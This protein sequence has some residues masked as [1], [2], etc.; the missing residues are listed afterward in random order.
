MKHVKHDDPAVAF[1]KSDLGRF[2]A[3]LP[4]RI[5]QLYSS[6]ALLSLVRW[7][8]PVLAMICK[9]PASSVT[10]ISRYHGRDYR[11]AGQYTGYAVCILS[12]TEAIEKASNRM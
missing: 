3:A 7:F 11:F 4:D 10:F 6:N 8:A 12:I 1:A 9:R 5:Q 2:R